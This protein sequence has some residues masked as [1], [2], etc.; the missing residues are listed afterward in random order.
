MPALEKEEEYDHRSQLGSAIKKAVENDRKKY[1]A[2]GVKKEGI[3]PIT[4]AP[5][6]AL[7]R[8]F[9]EIF[10]ESTKATLEMTRLLPLSESETRKAVDQLAK[11]IGKFT[12]DVNKAP[13]FLNQYC[14][15]IYRYSLSVAHCTYLLAQ[16]MSG[17]AKSWFEMNLRQVSHL[18]GTSAEAKTRRIETLL[19]SFKDQYMGVTQIQMWK[20][21]LEGTKLLSERHQVP[22]WCFCVPHQ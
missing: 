4:A 19:I 8:L 9:D 7:G 17:E 5:P 13:T 11:D 2:T 10:T 15:G 1:T 22:L 14:S 16:C 20:R 18:E 21:D 3:L 12:G 6:H